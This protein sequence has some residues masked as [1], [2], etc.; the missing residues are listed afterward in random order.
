MPLTAIADFAEKGASNALFR[1]LAE[2][3]GKHDGL[4]NVEAEER[5]LSGS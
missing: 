2:L 1:D 4:W 5:L 3:V